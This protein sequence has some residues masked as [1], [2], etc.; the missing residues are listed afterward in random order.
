MLFKRKQFL[1]IGSLA[2]ASLM[3]P[4]FLK[5]FEKNNFV[6]PGNKV[7]VVLQF[8]GGNDGLN[9]I[10]PVR[11]DIY[12]R[13]RPGLGIKKETALSLTDEAGI[14]PAL[15]YFKTLYDEGNLSVLNNVGYLNP[16]RSHFRSMDIWHSASESSE[17]IHTGWL[18]RYLDAQC[19]GCAMP[20]QALEMDDVLSL[21][22]KGANQKGL[23]ITDPKKLFQLT[24]DRFLRQINSS[25]EHVHEDATAEYLYKTLSE[26]MSSAGYIYEQS[27]RHILPDLIPLQN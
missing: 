23:A 16:D 9:T 8:S 25:H 17:Y 2:T 15:P 27:G 5:A 7:L 22:M 12:Y 4:K 11:N 20:V 24:N 18:G 14:H 3:M 13:S 26:T 1:Q 19:D 21:A 10:I 6:P